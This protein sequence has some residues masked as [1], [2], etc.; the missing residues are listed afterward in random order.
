[1]LYYGLH[2]KYVAAQYKDNRYCFFHWKPAQTHALNITLDKY[3]EP[4]KP[5]GPTMLVEW[6]EE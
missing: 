6:N 5:I 4:Y 3:R 1:M 2:D